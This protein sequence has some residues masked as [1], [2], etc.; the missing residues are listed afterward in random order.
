MKGQL[1]VQFCNHED[2]CGDWTPDHHA[3]EVTNWR[4]CLEEGWTFDPKE[5]FALCPY[6]QPDAVARREWIYGGLPG[7]EDTP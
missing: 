3:M 7:K 1:S 4:E 6:H 2:G 5:D